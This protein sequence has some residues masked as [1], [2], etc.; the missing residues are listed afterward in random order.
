MQIGATL[1]LDISAVM[2]EM[3]VILDMRCIVYINNIGHDAK[4]AKDERGKKIE[5]R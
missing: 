4:R 3:C 2:W 1:H 5:Q